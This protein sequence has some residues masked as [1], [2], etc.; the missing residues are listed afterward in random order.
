VVPDSVVGPLEQTNLLPFLS[1]SWKN[2]KACEHHYFVN[3]SHLLLS[4]GGC[5]TIMVALVNNNGNTN[6]M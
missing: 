5:A 6:H 1:T 3:L 2:T 4:I